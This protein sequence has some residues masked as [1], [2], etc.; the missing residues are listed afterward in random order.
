MEVGQSKDLLIVAYSG[1]GGES[2]E[3]G[4]VEVQIEAGLSRF[5]PTAEEFRVGGSGG[6]GEIVGGGLVEQKLADLVAG[7]DISPGFTNSISW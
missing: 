1:L 4:L 5:A 7:H 2:M 6:G 3:V